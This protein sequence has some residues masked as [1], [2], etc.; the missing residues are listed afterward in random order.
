M[1]KVKNI[2]FYSLFSLF[3][4]LGVTTVEAKSYTSYNTGD[5]ITVKVNDNTNLDFYVMEDKA[6]KVKAIYKGALG[7]NIKWPE[8]MT[9]STCTFEGSVVDLA[10]KE[11]TANWSNVTNITL[12]TAN[13]IVGEFDYT[14][15]NALEELGQR[16]NPEGFGMVHLDNLTGIPF[17][18]LN[19]EAGTKIFTN[20]VINYSDSSSTHCEIYVYGYAITDFPYFYLSVYQEG[21]IRP[22]VTVSKD[23]VVGGSYVS[24]EET[25]WN[26]FVNEFKKNSVVKYFEDAG[27]TIN[28]TSTDN[29]LKI[30][31]SDGTNNWTTNFTYANGIL[32]YVPSSSDEDKMIDSIW[33]GNAMSA[34]ATIKG[35]DQEKLSVWLESRNDFDLIKDG[36]EFVEEEININESGNGVN[37]SMTSTVFSSFKLDI[38]NGFKTFKVENNSENNNEQNETIK[39]PKTGLFTGIATVGTVGLLSF[40]AY[41]IL[42]KKNVFPNA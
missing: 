29:T 27:N 6:D 3:L 7:A 42:K 5:K 21:S 2:L 37:L 31:M 11:R 20:S 36:V 40:G 14:S 16:T 15:I 13:D 17:Y 30:E 8:Q 22:I 28:I 23:Y 1:K 19:N 26:N 25:L 33:I 35:Y 9:T 10:L 4:I 24:E 18:A 32:T 38:K 41:L 39:N 34:L 12:P